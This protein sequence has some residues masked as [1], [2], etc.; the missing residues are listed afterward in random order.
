MPHSA[1]PRGTFSL[2]EHFHAKVSEIFTFKFFHVKLC[3]LI[4]MILY[5]SSSLANFRL[6]TYTMCM[7]F[8]H[9]ILARRSIS[10][11]S[12]SEQRKKIKNMLM[13]L[14]LHLN[15]SLK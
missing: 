13:N 3:P 15:Y 14:N 12:V 7:I 6:N 1:G 8:A 4:S 9:F 11:N 10:N 5:S 2:K